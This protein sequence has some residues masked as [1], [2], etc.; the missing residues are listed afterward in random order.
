MG[1]LKKKF[2]TLVS[3][4]A[5]EDILALAVSFDTINALFTLEMKTALG[6]VNRVKIHLS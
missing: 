5:R 3:T 4:K 1:I 2:L 6:H